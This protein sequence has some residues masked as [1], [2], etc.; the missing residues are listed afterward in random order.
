MLFNDVCDDD[1]YFTFFTFSREILNI[2]ERRANVQ[3][4]PVIDLLLV[5]VKLNC[6]QLEHRSYINYP[7]HC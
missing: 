6:I 4:V 7:L 1:L 5:S 2:N 3:K